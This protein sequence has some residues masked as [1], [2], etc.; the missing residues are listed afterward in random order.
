MLGFDSSIPLTRAPPQTVR[1]GLRA[2]VEEFFYNLTV[3]PAELWQEVGKLLGR[4]RHDRKWRPMDVER[5]GGPSYKTVQA[6][7]AGDVGT[8]DSLD[9]FASALDLSIVDVLH[10]V[11]A[12][13][14]SPLS[15]EAAQLVRKFSQTTVEGRHALIAMA[16]A[17]P[18]EAEPSTSPTRSA[19]EVTPATPR[20][21]RPAPAASTHRKPR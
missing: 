3:T 17:L 21:P 16:N 15:P 11:L 7:E 9:K 2:T 14:V 20:P 1:A 4:A 6:I 18:L 5:A 10:S 12:S 13:T 8:V 19:G